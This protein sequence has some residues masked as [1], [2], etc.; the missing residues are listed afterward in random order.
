MWQNV[1]LQ[2]EILKLACNLRTRSCCNTRTRDNFLLFMHECTKSPAGLENVSALPE[3]QSLPCHRLLCKP[4]PQ[5]CFCETDPW[6]YVAHVQH[7]DVRR[8]FKIGDDAADL[9]GRLLRALASPLCSLD[10]GSSGF[11]LCL[12]QYGDF[13]KNVTQPKTKTGTI[14]HCRI[15]EHH[16]LFTT[17]LFVLHPG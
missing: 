2:Q 11:N 6:L 14:H 8:V 3:W 9:F 10:V 17:A 13:S 1:R 15:V 12:R 5:N 4:W 7:V 16:N